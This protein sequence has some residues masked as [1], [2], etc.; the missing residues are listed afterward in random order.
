MAIPIFVLLSPLWG[1]L[2]WL[3]WVALL[4]LGIWAADLCE[5]IFGRS[6]DGRIVVDE[7]V[8]Q[9]LALAPLLALGNPTSPWPL[10]TGFV[11]FRV[12]DIWK[13][14]PV[15]W[16]ERSIPGGWGVMMDDVLAG[17]LA[18]VLLAG[19]VLWMGIP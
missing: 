1:G 7:V 4:V 9:L 15:G 19:A 17:L 16:A 18:A 8:G 6:D 3:T 10:V 5:P 13:P 14:G 11:L 12:F 2:W